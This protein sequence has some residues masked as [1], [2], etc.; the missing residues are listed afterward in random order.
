LKI[1]DQE[2][3]KNQQYRTPDNLLARIRL[4]QQFGTNP[5]PWERW[6]F[7]QLDLQEGM[8][9]LEAGCG[10]GNLWREN[11][12]RIPTGAELILG[13]LSPNMVCTA[14]EAIHNFHV[15]AA[16]NLDAQVLPLK[17]GVFDRVIANHMLYHMPDI[18]QAV[19]AFRRV[20]KPGGRLAAATNGFDHMRELKELIER[21][22]PALGDRPG[23]ARRF[24]LENGP[25]ILG[26]AFEQVEVRLYLEDLAITQVQPLIDYIQSMWYAFENAS[27][28]EIEPLR[29]Y[30]EEQ[31]ATQGAFHITK[32]QGMILA[33]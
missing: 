32:S 29:A 16:L 4:H 24:A 33:W 26:R 7:D 2:Y 13:D 30:I 15:V 28:G 31:I 17:S 19:R 18:D 23:Q 21:F 14:R 12:E 22:R 9:I 25:E 8:R 5:Y 3:L 10:P 27:A 6:V 11:L 1:N 20:L